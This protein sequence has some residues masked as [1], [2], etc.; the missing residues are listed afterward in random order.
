MPQ[1][2]DQSSDAICTCSKIADTIFLPAPCESCVEFLTE[3]GIFQGDFIDKLLYNRNITYWL[4]FAREVK[5]YFPE[6]PD[7]SG[8]N[9]LPGHVRFVVD[10]EGTLKTGMELDGGTRSETRRKPGKKGR[11]ALWRQPGGDRSDNRNAEAGASQDQEEP[12]L[13]TITDAVASLSMS[14][15]GN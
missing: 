10:E 6:P 9:P 7:V 1:P 8:W 15:A 14:D 2:A 3:H 13:P 4:Q 11:Q 12:R 5:L